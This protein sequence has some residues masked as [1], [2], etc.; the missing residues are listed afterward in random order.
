[1]DI[2]DEYRATAMTGT[3]P[4]TGRPEAILA[5]F[6]YDDLTGANYRLTKEAA[7]LACTYVLVLPAGPERTV[8]LRKTLEGLDAAR[9]AAGV[10]P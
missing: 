1:M 4:L 8:S 5:H 6:R 2:T 3:D 9:R 10:R 7:Q